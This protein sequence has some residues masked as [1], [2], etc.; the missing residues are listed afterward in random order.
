MLAASF[1]YNKVC[2]EKTVATNDSVKY[3][4]VHTAVLAIA[5]SINATV[6]LVLF[7]YLIAVGYSGL[8]VCLL[9]CFYRR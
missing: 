6:F 7:K 5:E 8:F 1:S 4:S 3:I 9:A 2:E